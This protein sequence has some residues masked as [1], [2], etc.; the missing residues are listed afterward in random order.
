[1]AHQQSRNSQ[2]ASVRQLLPKS[3][4]TIFLV[5][6]HRPLAPVF[7]VDPTAILQAPQVP[8]ATTAL[9]VQ[10]LVA[11]HVNVTVSLVGAIVLSWTAGAHAVATVTILVLAVH[12]IQRLNTSL[13]APEDTDLLSDDDPSVFVFGTRRE[14]LAVHSLWLFQVCKP[15]PTASSW[16]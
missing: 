15:T 13:E 6:R 11:V 10:A 9:Q 14:A 4:A 7:P 2:A 1:M 16:S 5:L 12:Q 8:S 3:T